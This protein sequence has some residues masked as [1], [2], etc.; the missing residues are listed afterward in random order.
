[1]A[2]FITESCNGCTACTRICPADAIRGEKKERHAIDAEFCIECGACGRVCPQSAVQDKSGRPV[3][4]EKKKF[5][6]KP[7]FNYKTCMACGICVTSCPV[8]C[9]MLG[10]P[11]PKNKNAYPELVDPDACISCGFCAYE[12]P[13]EAV[14]LI[15]PPEEPMANTG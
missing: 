11:S 1:M 15:S 5:W 7:D 8:G 13:V 6:K 12:C 14:T 2:Y 3:Q 10:K 9:I 4:S